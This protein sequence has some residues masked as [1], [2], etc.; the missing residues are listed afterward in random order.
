MSA[1]A[2]Q[3]QSER[4]LAERLGFK[5]GQVVQEIGY[6]DDC[7][8]ELRASI[9]AVIGSELVDEDYEDAVDVVVLWWRE[10]DGDLVDGLVDARTPLADG[11]HI[12]LLTP[13]AGRAGHV[14]P[15]DIGEAAPTAGLA[16]TSSMSA[17]RDWSGTRLVAPKVRK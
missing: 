10:D 4:S 3:A 13:K 17:A 12:W 9:E 1:T 5:P 15:S 14:E 11:G 16:Q 6:D 2:G 7:D 8:E